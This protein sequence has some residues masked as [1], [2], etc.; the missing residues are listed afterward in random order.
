MC[1]LQGGRTIGKKMS[2]EE[3]KVKIPTVRYG[4]RF[5]KLRFKPLPEL[6]VTLK[7]KGKKIYFIIDTREE[8]SVLLKQDGPISNKKTWVQR[9]T[10]IIPYS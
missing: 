3:T 2:K 10:G 5:G 8:N 4:Q 9:A 7:W 6:R 1:I